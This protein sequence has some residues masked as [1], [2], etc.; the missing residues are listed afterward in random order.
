MTVAKS[1]N[2]T[3]E[4]LQKGRLRTGVGVA[5]LMGATTLSAPALAQQAEPAEA[6]SGSPVETVETGQRRLKQVVVQATRRTGVTVQ[7]VPVAVTAFDGDLLE[8]QGF[9][10]VGD[11]EQAA[12]TV[13]IT[14][15]ESAASGTSIS[16]RGIGTGSNN[17]GFEAAVGVL[18]DGVFRT[19]TGIALSELP[20]LESVEV[21]R[22]P[23]GTLF[24]R[25]TSAGVVSVTTAG[26]D[27]DEAG[28][29][30]KAG[31]G[32]YGAG[33][34]ELSLNRPLGDNWAARLDAKYRDRDGYI[35]DANADRSF[36]SI[37]RTFLRGQLLY[38]DA[39]TTARFIFDAA[40]TDE[41]CC[42]AVILEPGPIGAAVNAG[43]AAAGNIGIVDAD[44]RAQRNAISPNRRYDEAVSE[45]GVSAQVDQELS[46]GNLTSITAYRD[47]EAVR[48][49]DVD[50]TGIDRSYREDYTVGDTVFTQELRLQ[51]EIGA[52]DWL[53]GAFYMHE[54]LDLKET[55]R[56]GTQG[57]L[58]T[59]LVTIGATQATP[60]GPFQFFGTQPFGFNPDGSTF[61]VAPILGVVTNP[62]TGAPVIDPETGT[63][64]PIFVPPT[65]AGAG[66]NDDLYEVETEALALFT[67]NEIT[68][69]PAGTLTVGLRYNHETKDIAEDLNAVLPACDFLQANPAA[70]AEL[71]AAGAGALAGLLCNPA[72][73]TE[74]NGTYSDDRTEEE[75]TGT[76]KYA[77][78][79]TDDIL[80][81]VSYSRGFKA[82]GYNLDRAAF[83][84]VL[85]GGD[86]AQVS[87]QAFESEIVDAY[88]LGWKS[89]FLNGGLTI[90]GALF[91]QDVS[92][93]Q[94]NIFTGINF[95]TVNSDV[96]SYGLELDVGATPMDG[97]VIQGG[98]AYTKAE[99]QDDNLVPDGT[100]GLDVVAE[101]GEQLSNVPEYVLTGSATYTLAV[102]SQFDLELH[103]NVRWNSEAYLSSIP[104]LREA[105]KNDA[106]AL[107]GARV[108]LIDRD[109]RF[110]V[111]AFADNLFDED[112]YNLSAFEPPELSG[113]IAVYPGQPRFYG[114]EVKFNF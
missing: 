93:F 15:T 22:G 100:G 18:I 32:N 44:P 65:P 19:R 97:L 43:A 46:F 9:N 34:V 51:D 35:D 80:G 113:T 14:Q 39:D 112:S 30:L 85:F 86:G 53:V 37:E 10:D 45:W 59:D 11:L 83:D 104:G 105:T 41:S 6:E 50:F 94:E 25:N 89:A 12:P 1:T 103:G 91:F 48:D 79:F 81:Y 61:G 52:L 8:D 26:P 33:E 102:S 110:E 17:P 7:D 29:F 36:N 58:F 60:G 4:H 62:E 101:G 23:Q 90:N 42:S 75:V 2:A 96:E 71:N 92:G 5:A 31:A 114:A 67:H 64:I 68:V 16:I 88:E 107:A 57:D 77:H 49:Q 24:G 20:E 3:R 70:L 87:D 55:I 98:I 28:G 108:S 40:D 56:V 109:G 73:N 27:L 106:Y 69:S 111:S 82:G 74:F 21:L 76:V 72:V 66:Q 99:R 54:T 78:A 13:Q 95:R 38:E 47:W 84:A 63:P